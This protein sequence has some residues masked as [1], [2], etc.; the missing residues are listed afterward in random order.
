M[1]ESSSTLSGTSADHTYICMGKVLSVRLEQC[2]SKNCTIREL[3]IIKNITKSICGQPLQDRTKMV[4]ITAIAGVSLAFLA[5]ALCLLAR[6]MTGQYGMDDWTMIVT[7]LLTWLVVADWGLGKDIWSLPFDSITY[8]LYISEKEK[9]YYFDKV[10]Y[11]GIHATWT[12]WDGTGQ[13]KCVNVNALGW[14][15]G[16]IN[17]A[18]DVIVLLLPLPGLAKLVMP[19]SIMS[20]LRLMSLVRFANTQNITWDYVPVGYWSTIEVHVSVTC[21]C[22]PALPSLRAG[23]VKEVLEF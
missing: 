4:S 10:L 18:L 23:L 2:I 19:V 17:I 22:L 16:A 20:M 5:F 7:M 11:L 14:T 9:I 12:G 13:A 21:A 3:L 8:I 15:S 6:I 1:A